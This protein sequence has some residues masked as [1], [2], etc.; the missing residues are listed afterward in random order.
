MGAQT[1]KITAFLNIMDCVFYVTLAIVAL[2][3]G[4]SRWIFPLLTAFIACLSLLTGVLIFQVSDTN[5]TA[6]RSIK[7]DAGSMLLIGSGFA[8]C[9]Q[10]VIRLIG[11]PSFS[12]NFENLHFGL[13]CL[14]STQTSTGT[15]DNLSFTNDAESYGHFSQ[16]LVAVFLYPA[17]QVLIHQRCPCK[18]LGQDVV[19]LVTEFSALFVVAYPVYNIVKRTALHSSVCVCGDFW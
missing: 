9:L 1:R 14:N 15:C 16:A 7:P 3:M 6:V 18:G 17:T 5:I 10:L 13:K 11:S 8:I 4:N 12:G 2:A 19:I